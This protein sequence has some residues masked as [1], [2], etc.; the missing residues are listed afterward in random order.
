LTD[1]GRDRWSR[2][3]TS[4]LRS[5]RFFDDLYEDASKVMVDDVPVPV[6]SVAHLIEMKRAVR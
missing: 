1:L 6:A 4:S 2:T 5:T 3:P